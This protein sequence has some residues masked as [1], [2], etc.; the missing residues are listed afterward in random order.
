MPSHRE[1]VIKTESREKVY[2]MHNSLIAAI[3]IPTFKTI[4]I[5]NVCNLEVEYGSWL[6]SR[7]DPAHCAPEYQKRRNEK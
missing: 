4:C 2:S 3:G 7:T 1:R 6:K 5:S